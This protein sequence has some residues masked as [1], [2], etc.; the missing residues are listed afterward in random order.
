[1]TNVVNESVA[2]EVVSFGALLIAAL[3]TIAYVV[4]L[5]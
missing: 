5:F 4:S 2:Q 3:T 1:M